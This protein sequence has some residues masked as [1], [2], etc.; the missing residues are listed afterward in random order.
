MAL[1]SRLKLATRI[2]G[3]VGCSR[4]RAESTSWSDEGTSV[5]PT[6]PLTL[7][8]TPTQTPKRARNGRETRLRRFWKT[9]LLFRSADHHIALD[10]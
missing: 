7:T 4:L 8:L 1:Q 6:Q 5:D 3:V 2:F 10:Q 9:Y